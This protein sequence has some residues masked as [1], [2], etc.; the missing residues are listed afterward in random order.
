MA[1]RLSG[2]TS[3]DTKGNTHAIVRQKAITCAVDAYLSAST[4]KRVRNLGD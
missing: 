3:G 1:L 2:P 4:R